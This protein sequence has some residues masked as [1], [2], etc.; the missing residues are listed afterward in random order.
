MKITFLGTGGG[1]FAAISQKRMTGGFRIDDYT[2]KNFHVDPGPGALVRSHEFGLN[3]GDLDGIFV[4][5]A[6]T[7]HYNDIEIMVEA[8]TNG[9]TKDKGVIIGSESIFKGYK[10]WGPC[11]SK[12]HRARSKLVALNHKKASRYGDMLIRG[13]KTQ[14]GDPTG[15]GFQ[16]RSNGLNISYTSDT[17]YFENLHKYHKGADILIASVLRPGKKSIKGHMCTDD[18]ITLINEI[19]PK[20]AIMTHFGFKMLDAIPENEAKIVE[21]STGVKTIAASDGM[22]INIDNKDA[23]KYRAIQLR[24]VNNCIK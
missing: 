11:I 9:M 15:I 23:T 24:Q 21:N 4:S 10:S 1:R 17:K 2:G 6:H 3:P 16:F 12:Y 19:K 18:F 13:T 14:H 22:S 7:D 20:I 8:I 5:H